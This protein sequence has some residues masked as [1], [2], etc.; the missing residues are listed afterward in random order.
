IVGELKG[1]DE[2]GEALIRG[3]FELFAEAASRNFDAVMGDAHDRGAFGDREIQAYQSTVAQLV[4]R[5]VGITKLQFRIESRMDLFEI[6]R[7]VLPVFVQPETVVY[8]PQ[9]SAYVRQR[10]ATI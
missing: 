8:H 6:Q 1:H 10:D 4:R 2:A 7:K 3:E 9:R 5:E